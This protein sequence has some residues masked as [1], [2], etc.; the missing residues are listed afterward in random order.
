MIGDNLGRCAVRTG[1]LYVIF[2]AVDSGG[3]G[4]DINFVIFL[5][6]SP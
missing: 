5:N 2:I 3:Q 6:T 1:F 4:L